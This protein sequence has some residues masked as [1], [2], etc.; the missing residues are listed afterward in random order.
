MADA[1]VSAATVVSEFTV[2]ELT[3]VGD[4]QPFDLP[5]LTRM[6]MDL[7][8]LRRRIIRLEQRQWL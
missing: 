8:N 4:I 5:G 3:S 2:P 6:Q 1:T 7:D